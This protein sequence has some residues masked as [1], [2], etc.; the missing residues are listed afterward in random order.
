MYV[1]L[2]K[3]MYIYTYIYIYTYMHTHT[4]IY[5]YMYIYSHIHT[6]MY[7]RIHKYT[8]LQLTILT[9]MTIR[10][11]IRGGIAEFARKEPPVFPAFS[12]AF[13]ILIRQHPLRTVS[14]PLYLRRDAFI[15]TTYVAECYGV[16]QHG[17]VTGT[18]NARHGPC[19]GVALISR[20]LEII[21]LFCK[22]AP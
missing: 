9:K 5:I 6:Y 21:G 11:I 16:L 20:L 17:N 22:R 15:C 18:D 2:Y 10:S 1:Y 3:S 13:L 8:R 12:R 7:M 19:Y 14:T 4:H